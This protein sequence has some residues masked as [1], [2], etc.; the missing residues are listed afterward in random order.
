MKIK[1]IAQRTFPFLLAL[2]LTAGCSR[3]PLMKTLSKIPA[4]IAGTASTVK[5]TVLG[6]K[7]EMPIYDETF[8]AKGP[9]SKSKNGLEVFAAKY[10]DKKMYSEKKDLFPLIKGSIN[11]FS[12]AWEIIL[13]DDKGELQ[14]LTDNAV[15]E[16]HPKIDPQG[17]FVVFERNNTE[18]Y[19]IDLKTR[20]ETKLTTKN[21][22][23]NPAISPDGEQIAFN[24]NGDIWLI[25]KDGKKEKELLPLN[26]DTRIYEWTEKGLIFAYGDS[27]FANAIID[28][29]NRQVKEYHIGQD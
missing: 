16:Y 8:R 20:T 18:I 28:F 29:E 10:N 14:R 17:T 24:Y 25:D 7:Y 9:S 12:Q 13:K 26:V 3:I 22:C 2:A 23:K 6:E 5:D 1:S 4:K 11:D 27:H 19:K 15:E 21:G